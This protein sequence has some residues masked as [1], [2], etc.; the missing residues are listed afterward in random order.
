MTQISQNPRIVGKARDAGRNVVHTVEV[1]GRVVATRRSA[2]RYGYAIGYW[3]RTPS[4]R[5]VVVSRW[6]RSPQCTGSSFAI[7]IEDA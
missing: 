7:R 2:H 4:G 6:S 1:D 3:T 5:T